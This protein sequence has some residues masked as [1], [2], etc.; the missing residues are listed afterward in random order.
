VNTHKGFTLVELLVVIAIIAILAGLLLPTLTH[1]MELARRAECANNL[2]QMGLSMKMYLSDSYYGTMPAWTT[3]DDTE[4]KLVTALGRLYQEGSGLAGDAELFSCP[5]QPC[6]RPD[7]QGAPVNGKDAINHD[8]ESSYSLARKLGVNDAANK[9]ICADEGD[10]AGKGG[11]NHGA[12][13]E[14]LYA[15]SHVAYEKKDDPAGDCDLSGIYAEGDGG[16]TDTWM[17]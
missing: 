7:A 3:N 16:T 10:G 17:Y 13:Q 14:C 15:D 8:E 2:K 4:E 9:I 12:G 1:V 11:V 5:S 6:K